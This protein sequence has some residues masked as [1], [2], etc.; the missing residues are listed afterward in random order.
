MRFPDP[1]RASAGTI[2]GAVAFGLVSLAGLQSC[3]TADHSGEPA[4]LSVAVDSGATRFSRLIVILRDGAGDDTLWNDSLARPSQL[5]R[6]P[7]QRYRGGPATVVIEGFT[8]KE[9]AF[10]ETREFD[11]ATGSAPRDTVSDLAAPIARFGFDT[12]RI[13]LPFG[14]SRPLRL[15]ILPA[16]AD[17]RVTLSLSDSEVVSLADSGR[18]ARGA[19]RYRLAARKSGS[20]RIIARSAARADLADTV[21]VQVSHGTSSLLP[22]VN[23]SPAWSASSRPVWTWSHG[24]PGGIGFYAVRIDDDALREDSLV[25]DTTYASPLPLPDGPHTL[26]VWER[27]GDGNFSPA[28]GM[29]IRVD[30]RPPAAPVVSSAG[31]EATDSPHPA[32]TWISGGGGIGHYRVRIDVADLSDGARAVDSARYA[33]PESLGLG[34]HILYVQESDSA[35]NWSEPG[36][37]KVTVVA[38]DRIPPN[39]PVR[40][41]GLGAPLWHD[42]LTWKSGGG[43]GAG[44]YRYLIDKG[45][46]KND[47]PAEIRDSGMTPPDSLDTAI[48]THY[49]RV[50]ERDAV[51]NWSATGEFAFGAAHFIYLRSLIDSAFTLTLAADS[52]HLQLTRLVTAPADDSEKALQMRQLWSVRA[53]AG[54]P[55][56]QIWTNEFHHASLRFAGADRPLETGIFIGSQADSTFVW[57]RHQAV[58]TGGAPPPWFSFTSVMDGAAIAVRS[59]TTVS[60]T[61]T[62]ECDTAAGEAPRRFW[63]VQ[64]LL[65]KWWLL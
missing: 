2:A 40:R 25:A 43:G 56:G 5:R 52:L 53:Q 27:D 11:P 65:S 6:L 31:L 24:G 14:G 60:D 3:D 62:V 36:N 20:V 13:L 29:V 51:G 54:F 33:A 10:A 58:F 63:L 46:F 57:T 39:A 18:D 61:T 42:L 30:T 59:D 8:G 50:Q 45:D 16:K 49:L 44:V 64:P 32:W 41:G 38:P 9:K 28:A 23:K 7:T 37:A 26:Y 1:G 47:H 22:P 34:P 55:D 48:T 19:R 21:D 35:G 17:G 12:S 4:L 15:S